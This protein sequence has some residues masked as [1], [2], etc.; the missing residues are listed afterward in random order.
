[1]VFIFAVGGDLN[2]QLLLLVL[3]KVPRIVN[4]VIIN[5]LELGTPPADVKALWVKLLRLQERVE[6][7]GDSAGAEACVE[8]PSAVGRMNVKVDEHLL[9]VA[10]TVPP[11]LLQVHAEVAGD[12]HSAPIRHKASLVQFS[13]QCVDYRHSCHASLPSLDDGH[14]RLPIVVGAIVDT[15]ALEEGIALVVSPVFVKVTPK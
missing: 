5:A 8:R 1:M 14:V 2:A 15:V 12:E 4:V 3:G 13:H 9:K 11:V 7:G 6:D 10:D